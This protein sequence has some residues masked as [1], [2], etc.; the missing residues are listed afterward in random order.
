MITELKMFY[1]SKHKH[2][3]PKQKRTTRL[4]FAWTFY[5]QSLFI[6]TAVRLLLLK[7]LTTVDARPCTDTSVA[8]V[9]GDHRQTEFTWRNKHTCLP[10]TPNMS[11]WTHT[12]MF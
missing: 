2:H 12:Y 7:V 9:T 6:S 8:Q 10:A 11:Q 3:Q 1:C 4:T 5:P